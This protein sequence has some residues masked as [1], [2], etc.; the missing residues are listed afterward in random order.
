MRFMAAVDRGESPRL[1]VKAPPRHGKTHIVSE[2]LPAFILGN[3]PSKKVVVTSYGKDLSAL[4][5]RKSLELVNSEYYRKVFPQTKLSI[6]RSDEFETADGGGYYGVGIGGGLTGRGADYLIVD[7]PLKGWADAS[8]QAKRNAIWEW[9]T[10]V[11]YTRLLPGG[12]VLVIQTRWHNDDLAGRLIDMG[13]FEVLDFPAIDDAGCALDPVRY[14]LDRLNDIKAT[15]GSSAWRALYMQQPSDT[16]GAIIKRGDMQYFD[17]SPPSSGKWCVSVDATFKDGVNSDNVSIQV[18]QEHDKSFYCHDNDTRRMGFSDSLTAIEAMMTRYDQHR[19]ALVIE[20]KANG[21]AIIDTL[22]RKYSRIIPID[23]QGGKVSRA[24]AIQPV[25]E[26]KRVYI[27]YGAAWVDS[28]LCEIADFPTGKHDDQVDAMTQG[29]N[30][31]EKDQT[32]FKSF[33]ANFI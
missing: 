22:R 10:S 19:P 13:G 2:R 1:L 24:M 17:A 30:Y 4:C 28:M 14:P 18:W 15:I 32:A 26:A 5:T 21:S 11:A 9:Y 25:T 23:P 12:G 27:R 3:D 7:D 20:D 29:L 33:N 6:E 8:S 31:L 16:E